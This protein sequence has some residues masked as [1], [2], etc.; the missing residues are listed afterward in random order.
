MGFAWVQ[1]FYRG[2]GGR[3]R[4]CPVYY[5]GAKGRRACAPRRAGD[6]VG[7]PDNL[8]YRQFTCLS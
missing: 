3:V 5:V 6:P 1:T 8:T 7:V 4:P 2:K